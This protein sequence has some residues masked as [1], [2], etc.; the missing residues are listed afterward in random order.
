[1]TSVHRGRRIEVL[2][3][4]R[5]IAPLLLLVIVCGGSKP[6]ED[7]KDRFHLRLPDAWKLAPRFG[8][9]W[10][11]TF[12]RAL[13][14]GQSTALTIHVDPVPATDLA[15]FAARAEQG[16]ESAGASTLISASRTTV[17]GRP[18]MIREVDQAGRRV[19]AYFVEANG[20][21]YHLRF[22]VPPAL[23]RTVEPEWKA[24]LDS[25]SPASGPAPRVGD[26]P[27]ATA[28]PPGLIGT[29]RGKSGVVLTLKGER[30]F[31][32]GGMKGRF[33]VEDA[34]L[35]LV[36]PGRAPLRFEWTLDG[37]NLSLSAP[38]LAEPVSYTRASADEGTL[39]GTWRAEGTTLEL[40]KSGRFK[41]G[42]LAG[43]WD[44]GEERLILRGE[45]GEEVTYRYSLE[46]GALTLSGGDL[47]QPLSLRRAR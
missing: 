19:R 24:I 22:E 12:Q 32:M 15:G 36:V 35:V 16:W 45:Q 14:A 20:R 9:L 29:W 33:T 8:D 43:S 1:L 11:M 38:N 7:T 26:K 44:S 3:V 18:A 25:F 13:E 5:P 28:L 46:G 6:Y 4:R 17:A 40:N 2:L 27:A 10:G 30:T 23:I 31:S 39:I 34:T 21:F 41:M 47:E 42:P 37:D